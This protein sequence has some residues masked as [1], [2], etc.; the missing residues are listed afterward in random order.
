MTRRVAT[1]VNAVCDAV[2]PWAG[3]AVDVAVGCAAGV[4]ELVG[5]GRMARAS[6]PA[7]QPARSPAVRPTARLAETFAAQVNAVRR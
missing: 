3:C 7:E 6:T 1:A 4:V 5:A 2:L